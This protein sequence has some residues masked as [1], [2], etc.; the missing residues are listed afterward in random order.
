MT[1]TVVSGESV[2]YASYDSG[3]SRAALV[4]LHGI[5]GTWHAWKPVLALLRPHHRVLALTLPG[6]DGGPDYAGGGDATVSGIA[7]Q[8][9]EDLRARGIPRA[10]VAGNS[11]GGWLALELARRGFA[12]SVV[13][14]SPAGGWRTASDYRAISLKFRIFHAL[15]PVIRRLVWP[16][17]RFA[18][19]RRLL[20]KQTMEHGE[21]VS[22]GELRQS[23]RALVRARVFVPL[24][25]SM[26]RDGP[27][28]PLTAGEIPIRIAWGECDQV[29]PFERYGVPVLERVDSAEATVVPGVGH[30]PMYDDP[31]RVAVQ[32]LE[33]TTAADRRLAAASA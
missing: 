4:L 5:G 21:R 18:G 28:E 25:R 17:L 8:L 13:A 23:M 27:I 33:V 2:S 11:L 24:L 3:G 16:F 12:Q 26:G 22:A 30:V 14:L 20:G 31:E 19:F 7:D 6:H 10:H 15:M 32:I 29:I 1:D 9:V